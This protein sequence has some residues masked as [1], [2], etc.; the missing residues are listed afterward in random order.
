MKGAGVGWW[1]QGSRGEVQVIGGMGQE[2]RGEE[3]RG[4]V[5]G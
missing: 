4:V 3:I 1:I 2:H 5:I